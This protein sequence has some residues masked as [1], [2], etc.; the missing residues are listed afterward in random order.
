MI[1]GTAYLTNGSTSNGITQATA[2]FDGTQL[3]AGQYNITASYAG[4]VNYTAS[5]STSLALNL[6]ADFTV[7]DRGITLQTV[8]AGQTAQYINDIAITPL[9]G[10]SSTVT[11]TC[12]VPA[13]GT[14]CTVNPSSYSTSS[15]VGTGS[16]SVTTTARSAG[17]FGSPSEPPQ[18]FSPVWPFLIVIAFL[19]ALLCHHAQT[20]QKRFARAP[21]LTV[22]FLVLAIGV[23]G[24]GGTSGGTNP[25]PTVQTGTPAGSYTVTLTATS[26]SVTHTTTITLVVN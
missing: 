14:T 7:A 23:A 21:A 16:V 22:V 15:G 24:C 26:N 9:F 20:D 19:C 5:N 12:S 8:V 10:F 2:A 1:L 3:A 6:T 11:V 25:P 13:N 18:P 17:I 4:D